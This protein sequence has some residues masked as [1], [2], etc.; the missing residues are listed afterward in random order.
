MESVEGNKIIVKLQKGLTKDGINADAIVKGLKELRP[1]ALE[2]KDPTLTKVTRLAY[3]HI[4]ENK[5]FSIPLP[6]E[7]AI[8]PELEEGQE[9][10]DSA[11]VEMIVNSIES[12]DDRLESLD[13]LFSLML[14][15][16]N[17]DNKQDMFA[18][19]DA[20]KGF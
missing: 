4:E 17:V 12:D 7:E 14:D 20:L 9:A 18:Y 10:D 2:E 13:Y 15:R 8:M 16:E 19:R 1:F 11:E 3:E 5:T 6:P